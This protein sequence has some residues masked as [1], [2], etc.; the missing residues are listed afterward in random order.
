[1]PILRVF[2]SNHLCICFPI[3]WPLP[4]LF[5]LFLHN[6]ILF[7][8]KIKNDNVSVRCPWDFFYLGLCHVI[9]F[10][11]EAHS[12]HSL[13][14]LFNTMKNMSGTIEAV[15]HNCYSYNWIL[16]NIKHKSEESEDNMVVAT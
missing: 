2:Q 7:R 14:E 1:M 9:I 3:V 15:Q 16:L 12:I 11:T 4:F 8:K 6:S 13:L 5:V 10:R